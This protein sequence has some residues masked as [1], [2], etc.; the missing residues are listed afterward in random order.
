MYDDM[1]CSTV[2]ECEDV[3]RSDNFPPTSPPIMLGTNY[4]TISTIIHK[5]VPLQV[6]SYIKRW[7]S[8]TDLAPFAHTTIRSCPLAHVRPR[9]GAQTR[10]R[11][12]PME[13]VYPNR[14]CFRFIQQQREG[15][16]GYGEEG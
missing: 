6:C 12:T 4:L 8:Y 11:T 10:T 13:Q 3:K 16:G 1:Q 15:R 14:K 5:T 7:M 9:R 2:Y